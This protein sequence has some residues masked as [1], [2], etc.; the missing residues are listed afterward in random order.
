[1]KRRIV[2][3]VLGLAILLVVLGLALSSHSTAVNCPP[4]SAVLTLE[5]TNPLSLASGT[6]WRVSRLTV[7]RNVE[8][9]V[10]VPASRLGPS[11]IPVAAKDAHS[12]RLICSLAL[13]HD[14]RRTIF[15]GIGNGHFLLTAAPQRAL[16]GSAG[17]SWQG[18]VAVR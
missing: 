6:R 15:V 1:M 14:S 13:P 2:G 11:T 5:L 12:L 3:I 9:A 10:T 17:G 8:F 4:K 16:R 18:Y 7:A